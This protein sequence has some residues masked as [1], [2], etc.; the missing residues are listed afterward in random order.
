MSDGQK[1]N[2]FLEDEKRKNEILENIYCEMGEV[3]DC[4]DEA[5]AEIWAFELNI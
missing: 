1:K 2:D 3:M 4:D 5:I